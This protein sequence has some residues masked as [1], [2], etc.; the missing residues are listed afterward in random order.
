MHI[1]LEGAAGDN[2]V[3]PITKDSSGKVTIGVNARTNMCFMAD[4]FF[5]IGNQINQ[6]EGKTGNG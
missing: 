4:Q 5:D 1:S 3:S 2:E 6:K